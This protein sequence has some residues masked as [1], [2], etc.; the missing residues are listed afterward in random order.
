ML[1]KKRTYYGILFFALLNLIAFKSESQPTATEG[2]LDLSS[3]NFKE[4]KFV[5]LTGVWEFYPSKFYNPSDFKK[6]TEEIPKFVSIP[7]L[8]NKALFPDTKKPNIGFGTYRLQIKI[9]DSINIFAL[10]LKR[11]ETSYKIWINNKQIIEVGKIGNTVETAY[12]QQKTVTKIFSTDKTDLDLIIQVSNF[13]H[14]KGGIANSIV[15]GP[16]NQVITETKQARGYEIFII[17]VLIIMAVFHLGLYI[18]RRKDRSL[19]FFGLL[20]IT[21]IIS[22]SVNGET[23]LTYYFPNTDWLILKRTDYISNFARVTF[24]ALFFFYL[25]KPII[26]K[27]FVLALS[28]I[29]ILLTLFVLFTDLHTF[30]FTLFIFLILSALTLVYVLYAQFKVLFEKEEGALIPLIGTLALLITAVNDTL[31]VSGFFNSIYL[32][33][34][35]LFVFIFSQSYSLSFNFSKLYKHKEELNNLISDIED[36]KNDLLINKSFDIYNSFEILCQNMNADRAILFTLNEKNETEF[37]ANFPKEEFNKYQ[38]QYPQGTI[39]RAIKHKETVIIHKTSGSSYYNKNYLT[40]YPANSSL[41]VPF[42]VSG[43]IKAIAYFETNDKKHSFTK[44]N[45]QVLEGIATQVIGLINSSDLFIKTENIQKNLEKIIEAR[46]KDVT[47]QKNLLENQKDEIEAVN[48][49]LTEKHEEIQTKN[50]II[51]EN[52]QSAGLI[53]S[54]LLPDDKYLY[55]L[56]EDI[57]ILF[58]PK[59]IVSGDFYQVNEVKTD[60]GEKNIIFTLADCTGHG[61]PGVLMSLIGND[62]IKNVVINRKIYKPA[63]ILNQIQKDIA[64]KLTQSEDTKK[65]KDGMDMAVINYNP[66]NYMLEYAGAKIDLLIL[67]NNKITEVKADRLS[68]SAERHKK[69]KDR[70]FKNYKIQ[71]K[72]G[73]VLYLATDGYQD[74]F[75][76][77]N[78]TKFMKKNFKALFEEIGN[79]Q[80][81]IQRSRLLKTLNKWQGKN[82]QNDDITVIGIKI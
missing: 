50:T 24:F 63:G 45:G 41:T 40:K 4:N 75:G 69:L 42:K 48:N 66:A 23:L 58:R 56:F 71:L 27:Y 47:N 49:Q 35:G 68:I 38:E 55:T 36:L 3:F 20:L 18:V 72:K 81:V 73:D 61:V 5:K 28:G 8:W 10:R 74:Q 16:A 37:K 11:I 12:P 9:P 52:I 17:G 31:Y 25:Y 39:I 21:E 59:E 46:T 57:F 44:H 76:G 64:K 82:I 30:S 70:N 67:R 43:Q 13:K 14:R 7:S 2:K 22:M 60:T 78:D 54:A 15:L 51:T 80:F 79:L 6:G 65:I 33:P 77:E 34:V 19:L 1:K 53:Q 29:N 26:N 62:L 32:V